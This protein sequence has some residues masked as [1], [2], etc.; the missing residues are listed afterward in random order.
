MS[1]L[2]RSPA[3]VEDSWPDEVPCILASLRVE[4]FKTKKDAQERG[5]DEQT[6]SVKP[7]VTFAILA[8]NLIGEIADDGGSDAV[9]DLT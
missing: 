8:S 3:Y 6:S 4:E 7:C 1:N 2:H 5:G 9:S